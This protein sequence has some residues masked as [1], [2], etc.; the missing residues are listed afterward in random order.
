LRRNAV[1]MKAARSAVP[2]RPQSPSDD[3][4]C[5]QRNIRGDE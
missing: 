5:V 2:R 1:T 4:F 3:E